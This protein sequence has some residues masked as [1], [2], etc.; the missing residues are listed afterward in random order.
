METERNSPD[1]QAQRNSSV[2]QEAGSVVS[3]NRTELQ[4]GDSEVGEAGWAAGGA[5]WRVPASRLGCEDT[6]EEVELVWTGG[7]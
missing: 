7:A 4:E 6:E 2:R 1:V 3:K 5:S